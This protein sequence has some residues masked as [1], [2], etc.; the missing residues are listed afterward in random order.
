MRKLT[1]EPRCTRALY[2]TC[3]D[4]QPFH[5]DSHLVDFFYGPLL[6]R[7]IR[8][9]CQSALRGLGSS[10]GGLRSSMRRCVDR[11]TPVPRKSFAAGKHGHHASSDTRHHTRLAAASG[12]GQSLGLNTPHLGSSQCCMVFIH[13]LVY[14]HQSGPFKKYGTSGCLDLK[15]R[16]TVRRCSW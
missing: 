7:S 13:K 8:L 12:P 14:L 2:V 11:I 16:F 15:N 5:H 4:C 9:V 3:F 10:L 1:G 6:G